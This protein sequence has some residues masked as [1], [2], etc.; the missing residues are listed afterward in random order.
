[1]IDLPADIEDRNS[2]PLAPVRDR[3]IYNKLQVAERMGYNCGPSGTPITTP[4]DYC[5]RPVMNAAGMGHGGVLQFTAQATTRPD[6]GDH[7]IGGIT[8]PPYAAGYFWCEWFTGDQLWTD[9]INDVAV[10]ETYE[11]ARTTRR[12]D[13][14]TRTSGFAFPTLPSQFQGV[15]THLMVESIGGNIIE[16]SPRLTWHPWGRDQSYMAKTLANPPWGEDG[17][18]WWYWRPTQITP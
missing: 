18:T 8:Q 11:T 9:F 15:S 12:L 6:D 4:G 16:V 13:Y 7:I 14:L 10:E 1:M 2:Y 5:I 3:W 17:D